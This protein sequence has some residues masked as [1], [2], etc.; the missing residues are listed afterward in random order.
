MAKGDVLQSELSALPEDSGKAEK[1][2]FEHPNM[3]YPGH[4]NSNNTNLDGIIGRHRDCFLTQE[5]N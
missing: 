2:G 3:L 1:D 4:R 5:S